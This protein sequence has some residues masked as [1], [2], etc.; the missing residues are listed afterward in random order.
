VTIAIHKNCSILL[1]FAG[2]RFFYQALAR[3]IADTPLETREQRFFMQTSDIFVD[4]YPLF[5]FGWLQ[6]GKKKHLRLT[7]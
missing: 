4:N 3:C 1:A 5:Y 6:N 2:L 7:C